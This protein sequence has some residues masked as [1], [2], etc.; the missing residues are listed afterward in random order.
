MEVVTNFALY[1]GL[2]YA[3]QVDKQSQ[4]CCHLTEH[5]LPERKVRYI[6]TPFPD[7]VD[8]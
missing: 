5:E 7:D 3:D 2:G 4:D 8:L 1:L 6:S